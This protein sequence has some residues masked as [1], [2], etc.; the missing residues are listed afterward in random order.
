MTV[1]VEILGR[2]QRRSGKRRPGRLGCVENDLYA[3]AGMHAV[4]LCDG[5]PVRA[6][7]HAVRIDLQDC[8]R[9]ARVFQHPNEV[10]NRLATPGR[11]EINA[12]KSNMSPSA[13]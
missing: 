4:E 1:A 6:I 10:A 5:R 7:R 12:E 2:H 13:D 8:G 11:R 9:A 3:V